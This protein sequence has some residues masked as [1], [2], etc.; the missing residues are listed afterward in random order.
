MDHCSEAPREKSNLGEAKYDAKEQQEAF[1]P[2][3][4]F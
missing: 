2:V 1:L 3:I 4:T